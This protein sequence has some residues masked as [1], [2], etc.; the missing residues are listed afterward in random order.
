[1]P[2]T[3]SS[4]GTNPILLG[5]ATFSIY[6]PALPPHCAWPD[7][8]IWHRVAPSSVAAT[9]IRT[10][11]TLYTLHTDF[12]HIT[13]VFCVTGLCTRQ[14]ARFN[15]RLSIRVVPSTNTTS[16]RH[17]RLASTPSRSPIV[18][19]ASYLWSRTSVQ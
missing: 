4:C 3:L 11:P 1:M 19:L 14:T 5:A 12:P 15:G 18:L 13:R 9:A 10:A 16:R 8:F 2:H 6:V 7:T 17:R